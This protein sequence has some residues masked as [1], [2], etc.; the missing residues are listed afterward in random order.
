MLW[1]RILINNN[2]D[3]DGLMTLNFGS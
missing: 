1:M 2:D 3:D